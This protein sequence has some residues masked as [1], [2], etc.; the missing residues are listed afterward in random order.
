[1]KEKIELSE[2]EAELIYAIRNLRSAF[3]NGYEN[4][5]FYTQSLFDKL[6]D[7]PEED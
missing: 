6:V 3:P 1:M 4:L 5:L 2:A 7:L